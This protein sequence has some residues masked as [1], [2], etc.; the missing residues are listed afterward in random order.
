[1]GHPNTEIPYD[2]RDGD[3]Y[4]V[5]GSF[6]LAGQLT[7]ELRARLIASLHNWNWDG[8]EYGQFIPQ[9]LGYDHLGFTTDWPSFPDGYGTDHTW[10]ELWLRDVR[11]TSM[12]A[13]ETVEEFVEKFEAAAAAGWDDSKSITDWEGTTPFWEDSDGNA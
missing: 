2:Y 12:S 11:G 5:H 3:N 4:K 1:M 9:Q 7:P 6:V 10:H 8:L 13:F